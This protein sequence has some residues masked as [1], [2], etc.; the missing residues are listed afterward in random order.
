MSTVDAP[1]IIAAG[2]DDWRPLVHSLHARFRTGDFATGMDFLV[3]VGAAAEAA[4]HHPDV[5][6]TYTHVDITLTS[7][8]AGAVTDRDLEMARTIS[9]L[10]AERGLE[11]DPGRLT[12]LEIALNAADKDA[13]GPFWGAV[14]TGEAQA[15]D[16]DQVADP[17]EQVPL[18]WFQPTPPR[19]DVPQMCFHLDIWIPAGQ[20]PA[21]IEAA[22][23]AGG[24]VVDD[25][26]SPSFVVLE[27]AEGNK[28]CLC[29]VL[30]RS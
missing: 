6:L 4:N 10:A 8:D 21:R 11:A 28:A 5:N 25:S 7:H 20:L 17:T 13:I 16:G 19:D 23:A 18:L 29:T 27:D 2:L 30:D 26:E 3:D 1:T 24:R 14:L 15:Y 12:R 9:D 22:V